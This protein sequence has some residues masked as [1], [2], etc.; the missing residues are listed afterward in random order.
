MGTMIIQFFVVLLVL[1]CMAF[2]AYVSTKFIG[3][4]AKKAAGGK[5]INTIETIS[6][7]LDK[8]VHLLKVGEQFVLISSSGKN[9]GFLSNINLDGY[10]V[11]SD[12]INSTFDFKSFLEKYLQAFKSKKTEKSKDKSNAEDFSNQVESEVFKSNLNKLRTIT[13]RVD[14]QG[15]KDGDDYTNEK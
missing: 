2:L 7:G 5:Y 8:Q 6:L 13:S 10:E 12:Q 14:Y 3:G 15:T 11:E 9:I 1:G 4:K